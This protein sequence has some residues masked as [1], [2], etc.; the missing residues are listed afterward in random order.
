MKS[1][2]TWDNVPKTKHGGVC[3]QLEG[4]W[5]Y[6]VHGAS[7]CCDGALVGAHAQLR[8]AHHHLFLQAGP[9]TLELQGTQVHRVI[10]GGVPTD[11]DPP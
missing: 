4:L 9:G 10:A 6:L 5:T 8:N 3:S 2:F 11:V 1:T 7:S